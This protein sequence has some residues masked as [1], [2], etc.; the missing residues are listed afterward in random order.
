[1]KAFLTTQSATR[2]YRTPE[3]FALQGNY[4][5][6]GKGAVL[7]YFPDPVIPFAGSR[8]IGETEVHLTSGATAFLC[9][10]VTPG[11]IK[12]GEVFQYESYHSKTRVYWDGKLILW[13]NWRLAPGLR[14]VRSLGRYDNFTHQAN[15]FIFN[16]SVSQVLSNDLHHL[17]AE[18]PEVLGGASLTVE[19]GIAVRILG[20]RADKLERAVMSCWDLARRELGGL[21]APRIRK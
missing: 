14:E 4:F 15:L 5:T 21:P 6:L 8:Y 17:L 12:R 18:V 1:A 2:V 19:K 20:H 16:E 7:E 9:E 11:R 13:D 10:V 3:G